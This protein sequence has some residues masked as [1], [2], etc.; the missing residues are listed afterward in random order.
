MDMAK[1]PLSGDT[2][3][4]LSDQALTEMGV[5]W[6]FACPTCHTALEPAG[7]DRLR[8]PKDGRTFYRIDGIW[9]FLAEERTE[10]YVTGRFG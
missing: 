6:V 1:R 7:L 8:C 5:D 2:G 10:A 9:R 3:A 4:T